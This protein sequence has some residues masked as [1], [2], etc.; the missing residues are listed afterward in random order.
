MNG[1]NKADLIREGEIVKKELEEQGA[2]Q[3]TEISD[4]GVALN[5]KEM[6]LVLHY[7][8]VCKTLDKL[9]K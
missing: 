5:A 4:M 8:E 2:F 6:D 9:K 3:L 7:K 1:L